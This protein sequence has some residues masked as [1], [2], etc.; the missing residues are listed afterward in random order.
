MLIG[1]RYLAQLEDFLLHLAEIGELENG[2]VKV[3]IMQ[4]GVERVLP[5]GEVVAALTAE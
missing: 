4:T 2:V 1:R 5:L 3:K